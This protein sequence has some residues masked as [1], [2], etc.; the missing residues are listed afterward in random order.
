L[1]RRQSKLNFGVAVGA[2]RAKKVARAVVI[3]LG[4]YGRLGTS[5]KQI[6]IDTG[7]KLRN[8]QRALANLTDSGETKRTPAGWALA[9]IIEDLTAVPDAA[10]GFQKLHFKVT[11]WRADP[12]PPCRTARA[13]SWRDGGYETRVSQTE[14]QWSGR[15]VRLQWYESTGILQVSIAAT[16]PIPWDRSLELIG[17]L[18]AM[19]GLERGELCEVT[20]IEVN[21]DHKTVRLEPMYIELRD[22]P[23]VAKVLYQ[24]QMALR[25]E[26]RLNSPT[27]ADGKPLQ[28]AR[29]MEILY[30]GSAEAR[31]ERMLKLELD[32]AAKLAQRAPDETAPARRDPSKLSPGDAKEAGFG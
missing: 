8:V 23:N 24:R 25:H 7:H 13:W 26:I 28:L 31:H 20:L 19:L 15:S 11:N 5:A 10:F 32:L 4:K 6:A 9:S 3:H 22:I 1:V 2:P 29:A 16:H 18:N 27:G 21:A 30:E 12:P 14:L 17:W